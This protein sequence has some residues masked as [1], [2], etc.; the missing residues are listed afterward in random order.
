MF[1]A[2]LVAKHTKVITPKFKC[3]LV[4]I[5]SRGHSCSPVACARRTRQRDAA[6]TSEAL[7]RD[8]AGVVRVARLALALDA[9]PV[10]VDL[11]LQRAL[12]VLSVDE[13]RERAPT[14]QTGRRLTKRT[15]TISIQH[16]SAY[17]L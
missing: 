10:A 15:P 8:D 13:R 17:V 7:L 12:G 9:T 3:W 11:G 16:A 14:A 4:I 2:T 5:A 6:H 1:F